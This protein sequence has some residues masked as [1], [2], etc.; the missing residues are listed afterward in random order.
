MF[1]FI[2]PDNPGPSK[3]TKNELKTATVN[4][5]EDS[6]ASGGSLIAHGSNQYDVVLMAQL[7]GLLTCTTPFNCAEDCLVRFFN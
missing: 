5:A 6:I 4:K 3:T 1:V 2:S 7:Y